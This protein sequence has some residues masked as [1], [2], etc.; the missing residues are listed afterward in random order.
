MYG[1]RYTFARV[2]ERVY[3]MFFAHLFKEHTEP[4]E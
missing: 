1:V 3:A 4:I 2:P